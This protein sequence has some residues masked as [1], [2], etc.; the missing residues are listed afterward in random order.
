MLV[1]DNGS[2]P[3]FILSDPRGEMFGSDIYYDLGKLWHSFNGMYDLIHT[4]QFQLD[5][6]YEHDGSRIVVDIQFGNDALRQTYSEIHRS[7]QDR[8]QRYDLVANDEHWLLK[9]KFA[10]A[11]HFSSVMPFH[12]FND[13][14]E[15]RALALYFVA[16]RL[17]SEL[18]DGLKPFLE[19]L[20]ITLKND[21]TIN[22]LHK[23]FIN[24]IK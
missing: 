23:E 20:N 24:E 5:Y 1:N 13:S 4:D 7:V 8:I 6:R 2:K 10:E 19:T 3:A 15:N 18:I 22:Q 16:V 14:I 11:M 17:M 21:A 12:L 9:T